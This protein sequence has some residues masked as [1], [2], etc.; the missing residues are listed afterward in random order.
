MTTQARVNGVT[1]VLGS[2]NTGKTHLA[3]ER[4]L[5]NKT[6]IIGLPLRLLARE[7]YDKVVAKVGADKVALITGEEKIKPEKTQYWVCTVEAMP[8]DIDVDFVA[9]DEIQL[10]ND[11]ERGHIFTQR[12]LHQ[13]G[14]FETLLLGAET[15][16]PLLE[17]LLPGINIITRPRL[18]VLSYTGQKKITRL[19]SRSAIVSF[20]ANNVYEIAELVKRQKGGTA[21]VLGALSPRT[22]NAQVE[23]FQNGDVDF[24]IATDAIGMGLNLD[25]DHVAFSSTSK[26]DGFQFRDL[27]PAELAQIAG[28]AGRY[29]KD[30]SFGVTGNADS[31]DPAVVER[32][33]SH[34]FEPIKVAQ[35]RNINLDFSTLSA[36]KHS[37][38]LPSDNILL[39]RTPGGADFVA[40][41]SL[42]D[43]ENITNYLGSSQD[44]M[45]LWDICQ[46]PDYRKIS[47][48]SH[49]ELIAHLFSSLSKHGVV[50]E[51]WFAEQVKYC[52]F[53]DGDIDTLSQRVAYIRTWKYIAYRDGWLADPQQWRGTTSEVEDRLSDALHAKLQERFVDKRTS[54]L[55]NKLKTTSNIDANIDEQ[56]E[57]AVEGQHVGHVKGF[58]FIPDPSAAGSEAKTLR[59][60]AQQVLAREIEQR[61]ER[62]SKGGDD[63]LRLTDDLQILWRDVAVAR[64]GAGADLLSPEIKIIADEQLTGKYLDMVRE[65][66]QAWLQNY[67]EAHISDLIKIRDAEDVTGIGRG[68]AFRLYENIGILNRQDCAEDVKQLSQD[69]RAKLRKLGIRFGAYSLFTPRMMKPAPRRLLALLWIIKNDMSL[70][71]A[72]PDAITA[73]RLGRTS[74]MPQGEKL[75]A[76]L[77][78]VGYRI[79]KGRAV[80][81]DILERL[82]EL[83]RPLVAWNVG[84]EGGRPE[85]AYEQ[86]G[87][88]ITQDMISLLGCNNDDMKEVLKDLG[89]RVDSKK[90]T[91]EDWSQ[92]QEKNALKVEN[93]EAGTDNSETDK[94]T[95]SEAPTAV[96]EEKPAAEAVSEEAKDN[97]AVAEEIVLEIWRPNIKRAHN[98]QRHS[99]RNDADNNSQNTTG[100]KKAFD[101]KYAKSRRD[102]DGGEP[103]HKKGKNN[104]HRNQKHK[105]G[106]NYSHQSKQKVADPDSPFAVLQAL[107]D[108]LKK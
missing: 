107:K 100:G 70:L 21:V 11:F 40:L 39:T 5:A 8:Q 22:R 44:V 37:L 90:M 17:Q 95:A 48:A 29:K 2:T 4:M 89:Y 68:I 96:S 24:M 65:R 56:G 16:R 49:T 84:D 30:G 80:R 31:L 27:N 35:W 91:A 101:Q 87:F 1:A 82:G 76:L 86:L 64:L 83:I 15:M 73:M 74:F 50:Q 20:S 43:D 93:T 61:A 75:I 79:V 51:D 14:Q 94:T 98:Q 63:V 102:E 6:A 77:P 13:R 58:Q 67:F 33:E 66:V 103:R 42:S 92:W 88:F 81:V 60:A 55:M 108:N 41:E 12:L 46:L 19:P 106:G 69:E 9:I 99:K 32:I 28:R 3:V 34:S 52:D 45:R 62:F 10:V 7:I 71:P 78:L 54:V 38:T 26:F 85:G 57:I 53:A 59:N 104:K 105:Q 23:M 97:E 72:L 47:P 25:L 18:S 36:L